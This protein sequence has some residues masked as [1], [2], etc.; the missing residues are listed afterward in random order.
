MLK[1]Q[2]SLIYII[3]IFFNN[4]L[5][6]WYT[7]ILLSFLRGIKSQYQFGDKLYQLKFLLIFESVLYLY[8][9]F[10]KFHLTKYIFLN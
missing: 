8:E 2:L 5:D 6:L 7:Q 3:L 4:G 1:M 9:N 10:E